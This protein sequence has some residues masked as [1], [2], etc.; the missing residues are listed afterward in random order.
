PLLVLLEFQRAAEA[1]PGPTDSFQVRNVAITL[2]V[3]LLTGLSVGGLVRQLQ[4][5]T[6]LADARAAEA[7]ALRDEM[8]RHADQLEIVNRCARALSSSLELGEAFRRFVQEVR[9]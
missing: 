2:V 3:Q 5:E 6:E 8:G 7:E 1:P 4:G 9:T